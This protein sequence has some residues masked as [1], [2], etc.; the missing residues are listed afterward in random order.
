LTQTSRPLNDI[1]KSINRLLE[2]DDH[3]K[4]LIPAVDESVADNVLVKNLR[5]QILDKLYS[6]LEFVLLNNAN[7][8]LPENLLKER[9]A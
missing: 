3:V 6:I 1:K 9:L 8:Q 4:R 7:N 2:Q 5:Q